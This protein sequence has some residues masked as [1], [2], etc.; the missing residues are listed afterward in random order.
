[1]SLWGGWYGVDGR[2]HLA[3]RYRLTSP[4]H[5]EVSCRRVAS[6]QF[7]RTGRSS[8]LPPSSYTLGGLVLL[9]WIV[10]IFIFPFP[11]SPV[12][13]PPLRRDQLVPAAKSA[14][15]LQK[16]LAS[17]GRDDEAID[18]IA[19][20]ANFNGKPMPNIS[21]VDL[22]NVCQFLFVDDLLAPASPMTPPCF[23]LADRGQVRR[24]VSCQAP[25]QGHH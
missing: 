4:S 6:R 24:R 3:S 19:Y 15:F 14:S 9:C 5:P 2:Q 25:Q 11:E 12:S 23:R 21:A 10:R 17:Q 1:V 7:L 8:S 18:T 16:W 13:F 22:K 20:V